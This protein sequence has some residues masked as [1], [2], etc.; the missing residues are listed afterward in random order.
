[1]PFDATAGRRQV[2]QHQQPRRRHSPPS[3]AFIGD[4]RRQ[5][6]LLIVLAQCRLD[7]HELCL[8]LDHEE[9]PRGRVPRKKVDRAAFAVYGVRD[10]G[11]RGP[12]ACLQQLGHAT[13]DCGMAFVEQTIELSAS[14]A[15]GDHQVRIER[16]GDRSDAAYRHVTDAS[17]LDPGHHIPAFAGMRGE[18]RLSPTTVVAEGPDPPTDPRAVHRP[19]VTR[20]DH[21]ALSRTSGFRAGSSAQRVLLSAT[22]RAA[23]SPNGCD[24]RSTLHAPRGPDTLGHAATTPTEHRVHT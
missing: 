2:R 8:D 10:L 21:P 24:P 1:V 3:E 22:N 19:S 17:T 6:D 12:A 15:K 11:L 7:R 9:C 5:P 14:P 20:P 13:Q 23:E 18:I 16:A 4:P